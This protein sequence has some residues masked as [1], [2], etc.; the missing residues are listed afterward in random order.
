[1]PHEPAQPTL[2]L[3]VPGS[4]SN[5]GTGFDCLGLPL[6]LFLE[7][8]ARELPKGATTCLE[9]GPGCEDWPEGPE[10]LLSRSLA[11]AASRWGGARPMALRVTS[12]LPIGRG[13]G[14]SAAAIAA[15]LLIAAHLAEQAPTRDELLALGIEL[16]GHPDNVV[17]ALSGGLCHC[18]PAD[19]PVVLRPRLSEALGF[20]LA[21]PEAR[22]A[23]REAR[24]VLSEQVPHADAVE[25]AR[26]LPVLLEGL[27][28]ADARLLALGVQDRLHVDARLGLIPGGVAALA[29]ARA[30]GAW[31][32][33]VSGS[34]ST[35]LALGAR[36]EEQPI[37]DAMRAAF[38]AAGES[39]T[40]RVVRPV[41]TQPE[42]VRA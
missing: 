1:M 22:I 29:A 40:A 38:E 23:T 6:S 42:I 12:E 16:E 32:A 14:S 11:H 36:G 30:A 19:P 10:E 9:R 35:L 28:T 8:E 5:L 21:W 33:T 26:R 24:A 41:L 2:R 31:A 15:G 7:V 17:P 4:T 39:A 27:A 34:G 25:N 13:L 37:A 20:A 18:L 3:R